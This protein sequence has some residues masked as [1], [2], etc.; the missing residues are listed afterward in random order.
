MWR[1]RTLALVI[2]KKIRILKRPQEEKHKISKNRRLWIQIQTRIEVKSLIRIGTKIACNILT[3]SRRPVKHNCI[4]EN[5]ENPKTED[6]TINSHKKAF[7]C[8]ENGASFLNRFPSL[9]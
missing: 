1:Y 6:I 5:T 8:W 2:R 3:S 7:L 9:P 4:A